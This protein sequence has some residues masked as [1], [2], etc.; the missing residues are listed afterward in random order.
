MPVFRSILVA[1]DGSAP[2]LQAAAIAADLVVAG[3]GTLCFVHVQ[4]EAIDNASDD[5]GVGGRQHEEGAVVLEQAAAHAGERGVTAATELV[6][7]NIVHEILRIAEERAADLIV[8]GTNARHGLAKLML[9]SVAEGVLHGAH[10]P[11]MIVRA[12]PRSDAMC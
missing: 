6:A 12:P 7:G 10:V 1:V 3:G 8:T 11:V 4:D 9:G 2:S 5:P